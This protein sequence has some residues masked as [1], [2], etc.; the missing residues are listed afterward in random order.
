MTN[1]CFK[2]FREFFSKEIPYS[3]ISRYIC[4]GVM[5]MNLKLLRQ[6][7]SF[8][9]I[10]KYYYFL[11]T[12]GL[13]YHDQLLINALFTDKIGFLPAKYGIF[14]I[15]HKYIEACKKKRPL[16]YNKFQ[17]INAN[18]KP[19]I[20][21]IFGKIPSKPWLTEGNYQIKDEWNYYA[22]KTGY[23]SLICKFFKN[24]CV[25]VKFN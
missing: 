21:H 25:N 5:L 3:N 14:Q 2:G 17:L 23:Y 24:A 20:R 13:Y 1:F 6:Y 12:K 16:I 7:Q 8:Q 11:T 15:N 22:N 4:S 9:K 10:T 18:K 19:I